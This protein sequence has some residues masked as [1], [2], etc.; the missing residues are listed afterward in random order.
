MEQRLPERGALGPY[1]LR[2]NSVV[3]LAM[4]RTFVSCKFVEADKDGPAGVE[5]YRGAADGLPPASPTVAAVAADLLTLVMGRKAADV[6][7]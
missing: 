7:E 1:Y 3:E 2:D 4:W 6:D 5:W